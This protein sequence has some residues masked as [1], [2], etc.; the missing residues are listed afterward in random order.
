VISVKGRL[1]EGLVT[2]FLGVLVEISSSDCWPKFDI[3]IAITKAFLNRLF[4]NPMTILL[5]L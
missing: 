1:N 3:E 2:L 5:S 4:G